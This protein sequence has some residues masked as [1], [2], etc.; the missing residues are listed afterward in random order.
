MFTYCLK[1]DF[2]WCS[3]EV[4]GTWKAGDGKG[5]ETEGISYCNRNKAQETS[6]MNRIGKHRKEGS[7]NGCFTLLVALAHFLGS[8]TSLSMVD[9][10]L[11]V[12]YSLF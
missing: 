2:V 6:T 11:I 5:T 7:S 3:I 9:I 12:N 10:H 1:L 4:L 8:D